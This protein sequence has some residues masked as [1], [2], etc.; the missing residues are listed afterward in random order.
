MAMVFQFASDSAGTGDISFRLASQYLKQDSNWT[1]IWMGDCQ[2]NKLCDLYVNG[3]QYPIADTVVLKGGGEEN[4]DPDPTLWRLWQNVDFTDIDFVEG[5]NEI[6]LRFK[7]HDYGD[8]SQSSFN[9]KFTAN[10]DSLIVTSAECTISPYAITSYNPSEVY[11]ETANESDK[12]V[13]YFVIEGTFNYSGYQAD[14]LAAALN[15]KMS[16]D[17]Q[18]DLASSSSS[19]RFLNEA[20]DRVVT[21]EAGT[22]GQGT[23]TMKVNV[24][25]LS[26][27]TTAKY[28]TH[29]GAG[30]GNLDMYN[31][32][33]LLQ[34]EDVKTGADNAVETAHHT[35]TLVYEP[36]YSGSNP[37]PDAPG[38]TTSEIRKEHYY[39][40]VGLM[41]ESDGA[42]Y[43]AT[44]ETAKL[45]VVGDKVYYVINGTYT[46][47]KY[48][49][50]ELKEA[51]MVHYFD[52]QRNANIGG[53][54]SWTSYYPE[55]V[56]VTLGA[57]GTYTVKYDVTD[58]P[59][60]P[61]TSHYGTK[62]DGGA[63]DFKPADNYEQTV[64][65]G[66]RTYIMTVVAG[67]SQGTEFWGCVG[68][69]IST[70]AA[71]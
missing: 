43:S 40:C 36:E 1:P 18:G 44:A 29:F 70:P 22:N 19:T 55:A 5:K 10:I 7:E 37:S 21:V 68:L 6:E 32:E 64:S 54:N 13:P 17:F 28:S 71:V 56:E 66:G 52:L 57:D 26:K 3:V 50:D 67:S 48:S 34:P 27:E 45:E 15:G 14:E 12:T 62:S 46:V 33:T 38:T 63:A 65:C 49:D 59:D 9:N 23:F 69:T 51:L 53:G 8:C 58:L 60:N 4:G 25:S 61:Y 39:G 31:P 2:F 20:D 47:E 11:L 35:Y 16:F 41:I 30:L 42:T 24:E